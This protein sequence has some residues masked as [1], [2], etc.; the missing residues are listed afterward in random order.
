MSTFG[1]FF[2]A[3]L[4]TGAFHHCTLSLQL[5]PPS[6]ELGFLLFLVFTLFFLLTLS[7]SSHKLD[8]SNILSG[9]AVHK[10]HAF[11]KEILFLN[12]QTANI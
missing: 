10:Q 5:P 9:C 4:L 1:V 8:Y 3:Q 7:P 11:A 6:G 2:N 12:N